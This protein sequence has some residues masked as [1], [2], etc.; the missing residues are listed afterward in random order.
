MRISISSV[1]LVA[2]IAMTAS[3]TSYREE[4]RVAPLTSVADDTITGWV[5]AVRAERSGR[6]ISTIVTLERESPGPGEAPIVEFQSPG[7]TVDGVAM[8]VSG[9]PRF[10]VGEHVRVTVRATQQGLRLAGLASGKQTLP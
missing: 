7:G 1:I 9:A 4:P 3:A 8:R 2:G 10:E 5:R 6:R